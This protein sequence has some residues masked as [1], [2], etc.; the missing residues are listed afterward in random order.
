[1]KEKAVWEREQGR[2]LWMGL[3]SSAVWVTCISN[4]KQNISNRKP[5]GRAQGG[6]GCQNQALAPARRGER[7]AVY[8]QCKLS[9]ISGWLYELHVY[10]SLRATCWKGWTRPEGIVSFNYYK[11]HSGTSESNQIG[12][13]LH[14]KPKCS[15]R[16]CKRVQSRHTPTVT[17][18]RAQFKP[19][20]ETKMTWLWNY[21]T[22]C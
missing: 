22:G 7:A 20:W 11:P 4:R 21:H 2:R 13:Q 6:H 8:S 1:M 19:A 14:W 5:E 12:S 9:Q 3:G 15:S 16:N 10:H 18:F 17:T